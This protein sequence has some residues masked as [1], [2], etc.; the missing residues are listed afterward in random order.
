[1]TQT[2]IVIKVKKLTLKHSICQSILRAVRIIM[3]SI[4]KN[5]NH[6]KGEKI[7]SGH[8]IS[9]RKKRFVRQHEHIAGGCRSAHNQNE[10]NCHNYQ[11][12]DS[13]NNSELENGKDKNGHKSERNKPTSFPLSTA[14]YFP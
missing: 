6:H 9:L 5:K 12:T 7:K 1:M 10:Q 2:T 13:I 11:M 4:I 14:T 3:D 8:K